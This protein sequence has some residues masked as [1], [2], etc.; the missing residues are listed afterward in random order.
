VFAAKTVPGKVLDDMKTVFGWNTMTDQTG[1]KELKA[2]DGPAKGSKAIELDYEFKDSKWIAVNKEMSFA[3]GPDD[4]IQFHYNGSGASANLQVKV[5]DAN[6]NAAGYF[7][8]G[9]SASTGWQKVVIP[10]SAFEYLWG[11]SPT[12]SINWDS[13]SKLEFTLDVADRTGAAYTLNLGQ[14]GKITFSTIEIV[15]TK[16]ATKNSD[17]GKKK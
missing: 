16:S 5:F 13:L 3:L 17:G 10:R 6:G 8:P 15:N 4:A 11:P 2:A 14:P 9:G 1:T 12:K 7:T